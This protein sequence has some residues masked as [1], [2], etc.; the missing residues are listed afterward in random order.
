MT[1]YGVLAK[2]AGYKLPLQVLNSYA[3]W[4]IGT[5]S[6]QLGPVSRESVE[7]WRTEDEAEKAMESGDWTQRPNP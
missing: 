5:F 3:G 4:Y 6:L 1:K 7:Y 2:K